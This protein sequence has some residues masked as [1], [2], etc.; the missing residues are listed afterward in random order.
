MA[1]TRLEASI[2]KPLFSVIMPVYNTR[3]HVGGAVHSV[4]HQT[5]PSLELIV[6]DDGSTDG[7]LDICQ[8]L[9]ASDDRIRVV[10]QQNTGQGTARNRG[11]DL[12][13]GTF[14]VFLDSDDI[15]EP[16]L[17]QAAME[18]IGDAD[19]FNFGFDFVDE[20]GAARRPTAPYSTSLLEGSALF[21]S[22][23]IDV[24]VFSVP[25]NKIYRR[26]VI[27]ATAVR[28]PALRAWEDAY[29][30]REMARVSRKAV[31]DQTVRYHA[32]MRAGSTSRSLSA[33]KLNDAIMLFDLE[34]QA[35]TAELIDPDVSTL[36]EAHRIKFMMHLMV[37]AAIRT[38]SADEYRRCYGIAARNGFTKSLDPKALSLLSPKVRVVALLA[39]H[40][41]LLRLAVRLAAA[42]G[43][44]PY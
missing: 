39:R 4:L 44:R 26:D 5:Q 16:D 2:Q 41:L 9:A 19:F 43:L 37:L 1:S 10:S 29:F 8:D 33:D 3:E 28:F 35:F 31:F 40:P 30:S 34:R 11:L 23:L 25:W 7:S 12:A 22:A 18:R 27:E 42:L 15:L 32:L 17:L 13:T 6:I 14:V 21:R 20:H 24:D 38:P 36:F